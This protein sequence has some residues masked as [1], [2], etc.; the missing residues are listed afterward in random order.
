M[1]VQYSKNKCTLLI[2]PN[3][4]T[5]MYQTISR[6]EFS[7]QADKKFDEKSSDVEK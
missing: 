6:Q 1:S 7:Q 2:M 3:T 4:I 5:K